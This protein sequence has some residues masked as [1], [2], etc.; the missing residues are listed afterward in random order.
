MA[1]CISNMLMA[2]DMLMATEYQYLAKH[3]LNS[4]KTA[5][6]HAQSTHLDGIDGGGVEVHEK[7]LD[8]VEKQDAL[9]AFGSGSG[10]SRTQRKRQT[11]S[12]TINFIHLLPPC[13]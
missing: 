2:T 8:E 7:P 4:S 5:F 6:G 1:R 9:S 10:K 3:D 11:T 13:S 12:S